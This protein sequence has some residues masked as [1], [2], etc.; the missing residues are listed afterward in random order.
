MTE[1]SASR[2]TLAELDGLPRLGLIEAATPITPLPNL[3]SELG[4]EWLGV[5]RDD[6]SDALCGGTKPRKLD[7]L[8]AIP[9]W[10]EAERWAATGAIGSGNIVALTAA[11]AQL[12]RTLDAHLF[13]EPPNEHILDSL[14]YIASG[15]TEV[16]FHRNRVTM[17]LSS[18]ALLGSGRLGSAQV[19]PP[20]AT[21]AAAML[22]SARAALELA[23]QIDEGQLPVPDRIYLS[24]GSGGTAVGLAVGLVLAGLGT[25]VVAVSAVERVMSSGRRARALARAAEELLLASDIDARGVAAAMRLRLD[26][27]QVGRGYAIPTK[28]G[29]R[30]LRRL[31]RQRIELEAVYTAKAM[32][33]LLAQPPKGERVLFWHTAHLGPLPHEHDWNSRVP[34]ALRRRLWALGPEGQVRKLRRRKVLAVVGVALLGAT[35]VRLTGYDSAP[36][37][38][39]LALASWE[40][41]VLRAAAEAL[42]PRASD[43]ELDRIPAAVD[44]YVASMPTSTLRELGA[45]FAVLEHGTLL[46]GS[47]RR[48]T[49]LSVED[50]LALLEKLAARDDLLGQIYGGVR[51]LCMLA[52]YQQPSTWPA[53]GYGGPLVGPSLPAADPLRPSWPSYDALRAP[54]GVLPDGVIR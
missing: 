43:G 20:G 35:A 49:A 44:R 32:A 26:H 51:E 18:P 15:P 24:F 33:A 37:F 17:A 25:Q 4:V 16:V 6:L 1:R 2:A 7:Y 52:Y 14:A 21:A 12:G 45:A 50:R 46:G 29:R 38:Q 39:G 27:G 30:A 23:A 31:A 48:F 13:W 41:Q 10:S 34:P 53:I 11:A 3:A 22:G 54:A 8:L 19:V 9:P 42:I 40:G 5:K 36:G 28:A 47:L